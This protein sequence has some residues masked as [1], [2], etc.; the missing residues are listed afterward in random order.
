M[1]KLT[2]Q[3]IIILINLGIIFA[4]LTIITNNLN[5]IGGNSENSSVYSD[6]IHLD[7]KNLKLSKITGKIHIDNN[8]SA[9]MSVGICMGNGTYSDPYVI[10]DL[11][12]DGGSSGSCILIENSNVYFKIENCTVYNSGSMEED[13][14]I[15]L[16]N[17]NNSLLINNNCSYN[18][19]GIR[20]DYSNNNTVSANTAKNTASPG[21]IMDH[22]SNNNISG[23]TVWYNNYGIELIN[24]YNNSISGNTATYSLESG[25]YLFYSDNNVILG[26]IVNDNWWWGRYGIS[27]WF[28]RNI[29]ISKNKMYNCGLDLYGYLSLDSLNVDTTNLVNGKP[30]YY[31]NSKIKLGSDNFTKAGQVIL[32]NCHESSI[33]NLNAS[34]GCTGISLYSCSGNNITGNT[35][36]HNRLNG[37]Y[38]SFS[39]NNNIWEN[40][41]DYN[42]DRGIGLYR[43]D[44]NIISK[45]N[46]SY[47]FEGINLWICNYNNISGNTLN[48]NRGYGAF[49]HDSNNNSISGNTANSNK[50]SGIY[51]ASSDY[52]IIS[53]NTLI[54]NKKCIVEDNCE[55]NIFINNQCV[56]RFPLELIILIISAGVVFS[57]PTILLIIL[58]KIK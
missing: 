55:G 7:K 14:G 52:N 11:V 58:K 16:Y 12:I 36:N 50:L 27:L 57:V 41:I 35:V 28:C 8:W 38:L 10:E 54:A 53:G 43:S 17:T 4:L 6:K 33:A 21:I 45:N 9:A 18:N 1:R 49:L 19:L 22:C 34:Y 48:T 20:L 2:K 47:N 15:K 42:N 24:S 40:T 31:Y 51:L 13:G 30:L 3:K 44:N 39:D 37:I 5:F 25:I 23:N 29:T 56:E 46:A 26:N 32:Y